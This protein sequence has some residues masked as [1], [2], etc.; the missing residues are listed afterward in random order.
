M[1]IN[2]LIQNAINYGRGKILIELNYN[3]NTANIHISDN[4]DGVPTELRDEVIKPFFR[5]KNRINNIKGHGIGLAI[6]TRILDLHIGKLII[7]NATELSGS[8]FTITL[9][10]NPSH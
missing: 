2:N 6:V 9:P 5:A 7:S 1:V 10:F 3:N 4:G 8:K